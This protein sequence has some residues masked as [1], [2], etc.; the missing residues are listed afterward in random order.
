MPNNVLVDGSAVGTVNGGD[1]VVRALAMIRMNDMR[2]SPHNSIIE[3]IKTIKIINIIKISTIIKI[4][5]LLI[6]IDTHLN[7]L[8]F[9]FSK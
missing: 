2:L 7:F 4:I 8:F 6:I 9:Y 5:E 1:G 3:I